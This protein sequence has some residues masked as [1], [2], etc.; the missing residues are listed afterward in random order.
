[1]GYEYRNNAKAW[2]TQNIFLEWL[3]K[4]DRRMENLSVLLIL[5]NYNAHVPVDELLS[6]TS[7]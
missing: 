1:M 3:K 4:L 6:R 2:M 7:S 5:D